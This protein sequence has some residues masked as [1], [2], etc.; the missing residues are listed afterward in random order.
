MAKFRVVASSLNVRT[1]AGK[2]HSIVG[3]LPQNTLVEP[4]DLSLDEKWYFVN[5]KQKG[6]PLEGWIY[7]DYL[8]PVEPTLETAPKWL[9]VAEDEIGVKE[10]AG[11]AD[12]PKII[13]YHSACSLKAKDDAVHWCSAFVNWCMKEVDVKRTDSAAAVSW[14]KW[15]KKLD[16]P[17]HG[18]VVVL[19]RGKNPAFGHVAF[20]VG[21]S[22]ANIRLL[23][24]NQSDQVKVSTFPKTMVRGYR[25]VD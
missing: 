21:E 24:G 13:E 9:K 18:C 5:L 7:K 22:D 8:T 3:Q 19:K 15:G 25:W 12:N 6:K 16:K 20:Y 14:L 11:S 4:L 17:R 23:G 1:G 10:A 2:S